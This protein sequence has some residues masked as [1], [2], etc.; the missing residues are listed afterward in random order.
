MFLLSTKHES[1]A[2]LI[3]TFCFAYPAIFDI[4]FAVSAL[5]WNSKV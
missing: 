1:A 3:A 5:F 4:C 2:A